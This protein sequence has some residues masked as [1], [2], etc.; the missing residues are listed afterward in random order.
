MA[1]V[2]TQTVSTAIAGQTFTRDH[3]TLGA[4]QSTLIVKD[5]QISSPR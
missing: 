3:I 5:R 1:K 4:W 2:S